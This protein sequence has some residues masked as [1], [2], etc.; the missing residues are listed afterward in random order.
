MLSG[1]ANRLG[2]EGTKGSGRSWQERAG[3]P[4]SACDTV[5]Q[6]QAAQALLSSPVSQAGP[7]IHQGERLTEV[8]VAVPRRDKRR[9]GRGNNGEATLEGKRRK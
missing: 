6:P 2:S 8:H 3:G 5:M 1:L 4:W 7:L 9:T